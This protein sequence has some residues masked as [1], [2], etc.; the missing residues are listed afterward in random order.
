MKPL[1]QGHLKKVREDLK[2]VR[3]DQHAGSLIK[4]AICTKDDEEAPLS[5]RIYGSA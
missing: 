5:Y 1:D 2:K 4:K 3:E